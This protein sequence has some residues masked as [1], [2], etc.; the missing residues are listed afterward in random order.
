ML[1]F[2]LNIKL[3]T[4]FAGIFIDQIIL[5][6]YA[7]AAIEAMS[8][9]KP[10]VAYIMPSVFK[11]GVS[12]SCPIVN[13]NPDNLKAVL[14]DLINNPQLRNEIGRK[15]RKFVEEF[16]DSDKLAIQLL[17]IYRNSDKPKK[18]HNA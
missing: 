3:N 6:S 15:S 12:E 7:A 11:K 1:F 8:M 10:T 2:I 13:A 16:H 14:I 17:D 5:G 9:G 18:T 4:A